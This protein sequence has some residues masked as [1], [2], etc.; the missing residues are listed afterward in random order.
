[1]TALGKVTILWPFEGGTS[2]DTFLFDKQLNQ[3]ALGLPLRHVLFLKVFRRFFG[4]F[5]WGPSF[6]LSPYLSRYVS[7]YIQR[8]YPKDSLIVVNHPW[9]GKTLRNLQDYRT[10][11]FAHNI[12]SRIVKD[13]N[14][15]P[16]RK[17][18]L[19][20]YV[21]KLERKTA[22]MADK[23]AFVSEK[24]FTLSNWDLDLRKIQITGVGTR[25]TK[26]TDFLREGYVVFVGGDYLFNIEA[27][28]EVFQ[29]AEGMPEVDFKIVGSVCDQLVNTLPNVS[30]LGW[31]SESELTSILARSSIFINP[32]THGSGIHLKLIKAMSFK[33]PIITTPVGWRGYE[34]FDELN[35][36]IAELEEFGELIRNTISNYE[37]YRQD[38]EKNSLFVEKEL[39]WRIICE[40]FNNFASSVVLENDWAYVDPYT[41]SMESMKFENQKPLIWRQM[42]NKMRKH[43]NLNSFKYLFKSI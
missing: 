38:A 19:S 24:D 11:Y 39:S 36:Q 21:E 43:P 12:E 1:M 8:N 41:I 4:V 5:G 25:I 7:T 37:I 2:S 23:V 40:K 16:L 3:Q 15:G 35:V 31:V 6:A 34:S 20:A 42:L 9:L 22:E 10:L 17:K 18:L 27:A 30:L 28:Q 14:L 26:E 29:L 32:M 13:S 33:L